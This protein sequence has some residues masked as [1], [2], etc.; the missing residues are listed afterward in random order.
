MTGVFNLWGWPP[1]TAGQPRS[2]P[3]QNSEVLAE[4]KARQEAERRIEILGLGECAYCKEELVKN[5][6]GIWESEFLVEYCKDARDHKHRPVVKYKE[7]N[8]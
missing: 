8:D 7:T 6:R 2:S 1:G 3:V 4:V 5:E